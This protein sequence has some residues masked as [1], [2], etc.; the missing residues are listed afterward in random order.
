L[1]TALLA[2]VVV[3]F[4]FVFVVFVVVVAFD[5]DDGAAVC[6]PPPPFF[7]FAVSCAFVD[8]AVEMLNFFDR[9]VVFGMMMY[10]LFVCGRR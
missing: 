5:D 3:V 1:P 2:A 8:L 10:V 9:F 7:L 4:V 6:P